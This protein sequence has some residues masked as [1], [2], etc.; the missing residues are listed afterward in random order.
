MSRPPYD[1]E[2]IAR[3]FDEYGEAEWNRHEATPFARV[4]FHVHRHYLERFIRSGD[5]SSR[6]ELQACAERGALDGGTHIIAVV[7]AV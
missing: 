3:S 7:R 4:A 1:A 2:P 5:R 6:W